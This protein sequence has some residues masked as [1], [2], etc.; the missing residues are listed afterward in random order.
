MT[1]EYLIS[2]KTI[3]ITHALQ[4]T[5]LNKQYVYEVLVRYLHRP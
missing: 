4:Y 1:Q 5:D 2:N 3:H